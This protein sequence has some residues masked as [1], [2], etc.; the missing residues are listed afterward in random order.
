MR[1]MRILITGVEKESAAERAALGAHVR[2]ERGG[3]KSAKYC[4]TRRTKR[5]EICDQIR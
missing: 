4:A 1:T 3:H 2:S 5:E